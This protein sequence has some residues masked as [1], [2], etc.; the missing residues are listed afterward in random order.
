MEQF[1]HHGIPEK[2]HVIGF[3]QCLLVN[4]LCAH[5]VASVDYNDLLCHAGQQFGIGCRRIAAAHHNYCAVAEKHTVAGGAIADAAA[6]QFPLLRHAQG[7]GIGA[8]GQ[9][10]RSA[11]VVAV[12]GVGSF[13]ITGQVQRMDF[14]H[15]CLRA[16][17]FRALLHLLRQGKPINAL[18][19]A[20]VIIDLVRQRHLSARCQL[21]QYNSIQ[22]G[23]C[24][25]KRGG[26]SGRPAADNQNIIN[27]VHI[28]SPSF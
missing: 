4:L 8:G 27:M 24:S 26:V 1:R 11:Q 5:G 12:T 17:A 7:P 21:F 13:D 9:N 22:T 23:P 16:E 2:L 28:D 18:D 20:R 10:H 15:H 14:R 6:H 3:F 19:K 25:I